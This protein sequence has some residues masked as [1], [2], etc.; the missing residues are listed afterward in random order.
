VQMHGLD[1]LTALPEYRNG[2]LL[3]DTG[4]ILPRDPA[5][6]AMPLTPGD[7]AVIEWRALT[8]A[9]IDLLAPMVRERFGA[10]A[11]EMPL[12]RILEGGTWATGRALANELR[13]GRPPLNIVTDG[14]FF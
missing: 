3:I 13:D 11:H 7:E 14:T 8:V 1:E 6:L 5:L 9:L 2:G 10:D 4:V 12:A